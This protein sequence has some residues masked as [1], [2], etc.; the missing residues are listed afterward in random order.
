MFLLSSFKCIREREGIPDGK[1]RAQRRIYGVHGC[2][3]RK[4]NKC[5][6]CA[7]GRDEE[8]APTDHGH[9]PRD[10]HE[11]ARRDAHL[12]RPGR[13]HIAALAA[14]AMPIMAS[15]TH[16]PS[17][18]LNIA[19]LLQLARLETRMLISTQVSR[20]NGKAA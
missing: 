7:R 2:L 17:S 16:A 18:F 9:D 10:T 8:H 15:P 5:R 14:P 4:G 12:R 11:P 1:L 20:L 3:V 13:T 19:A 6:R